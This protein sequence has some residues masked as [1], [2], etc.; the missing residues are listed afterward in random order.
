MCSWPVSSCI[1]F[2]CESFSSGKTTQ[3]MCINSYYPGTSERSKA[4]D[5]GDVS[6]GSS[7]FTIESGKGRQSRIRR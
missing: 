7:Q 5:M 1:I 6:M 3:K 2:Y 4:E